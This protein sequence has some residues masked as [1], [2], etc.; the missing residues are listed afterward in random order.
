MILIFGGTG[1][2]GKHILLDLRRAGHTATVISR[3]P[4]MGFLERHAPDAPAIRLEDLMAEPDPIFSQARAVIWAA[5][6]TTPASNPGRPW[7][8]PALNLE[9]L[10]WAADHAASAGAHLVYLSS[11]GSVYGQLPATGR[12]REDQPL[13]PLSPYGMG[14]QMAEAGIEFLA[15][16]RGLRATILRPSNPIGRWQ[17]NR[18]QGVVG[19]LFRAAR[20]R[21]PFPML[22]DGSVVR[23]FLPVEDL[24]RAIRMTLDDPLASLGKVWNVGSGQGHSIAEV[25]AIAERI[26]GHDIPV[27]RRPAR[28]ADPSYVVLDTT[29]IERDLGWRATTG[30][31]QAMQAVWD[32]DAGLD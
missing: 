30:L 29:R 9:P 8:E 32:H 15:R 12:I 16:A 19:A 20:A 4:E 23:D 7:D 22:G 31:K 6:Q 14:K 18:A 26:T 5:G 21:Q 1:F 17:S 24:S 13:R 11:G 2:I 25:H 10:I 3:S 27:D 28:P